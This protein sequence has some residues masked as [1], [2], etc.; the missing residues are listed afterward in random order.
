MGEVVLFEKKFLEFL[1]KIN[2]T[3]FEF[4][5]FGSSLKRK[6]YHDIDILIIYNNYEVLKE[7]KAK[8]NFE[9]ADFFPHLTCIT[10]NEEKELQF[11]KMV[12]AKKLN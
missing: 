12:A 6:N 7:V 3:D 5:L 1:H 11:I 8:I 9:F 4:Y 10:F 2:C